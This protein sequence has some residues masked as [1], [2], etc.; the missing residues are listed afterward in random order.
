MRKLG[1]VGHQI[2]IQPGSVGQQVRVQSRSSGGRI[3]LQLDAG[4]AP[5][6][7]VQRRVLDPLPQLPLVAKDTTDGQPEAAGI[8]VD[9]AGGFAASAA[10]TV[11]EPKLSLAHFPAL[12]HDLEEQPVPHDLGRA[13]TVEVD[14]HLCCLRDERSG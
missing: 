11:D 3:G 7:A 6:A 9:E 2:R 4:H 10:V 13:I 5:F 14:P 8:G 1:L 12:L